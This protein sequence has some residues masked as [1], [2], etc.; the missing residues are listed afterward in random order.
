MF[1]LAYV[2]L[3]ISETAPAEAITASLTRFQRGKRGDV[4]D[5]WL[6]F[7][8]ETQWLRTAHEANFI[9]AIT[10]KGGLRIEGG[11]GCDVFVDLKQV[12]REME[13][14]G[15]QSWN[16]RFADEMDLDTFHERF[17]S[18]LE[19]HPANGGY[20][21]WH[22]PLGHWDWWDLG[23]RFDGA[24][25]GDRKRRSGRGVARINSGVNR[26]RQILSNVEF[27]LGKALGQTPDAHFDV[28]TDRNVE[29]VTTL[30]ED[31]RA[32]RENAQPGSF[33]LPPGAVDDGL[34][35]LDSYPAPGP[36]TA[37]AWLGLSADATWPQVAEAVYARFHDHWAAG[38]AYHF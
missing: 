28:R 13:H 26:G 6:A 8:D 1:S 33:V 15:L 17:G 3:P 2:I 35:W 36:V 30:L 12:Q 32:G 25:I 34:R 11:D 20:G 14:R 19:R 37:L 4:P 18:E 22:N 10:D 29:L 23:G 5:S 9:F 24:I 16:V 7:H 21:E 27:A 31:V 38:V